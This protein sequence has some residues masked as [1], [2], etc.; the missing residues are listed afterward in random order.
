MEV[1]RATTSPIR[2]EDSSR[3]A[4]V[5]PVCATSLTASAAIAAAWSTLRLISWMAV[6]ICSVPEATVPVPRETSPAAEETT[7]ACALVPCAAVD[8][9]REEERSASEEVATASAEATTSR[10]TARRLDTAPSMAALISPSSHL[11]P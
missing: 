6:P 1:I 5:A 2:R 9:S 11:L 4:A 8:I 7:S 10:I 3:R